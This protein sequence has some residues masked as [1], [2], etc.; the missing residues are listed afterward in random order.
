[1]K[2]SCLWNKPDD[3]DIELDVGELNRAYTR[4]SLGDEV[5]VS[6]VPTGD[7]SVVLNVTLREN[8][9]AAVT[10]NHERECGNE[11]MLNCVEA[12]LK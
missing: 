6:V 12:A 4:A 7:A 10:E 11:G 9:V 8:N 1:L 3:L 5:L 2:C